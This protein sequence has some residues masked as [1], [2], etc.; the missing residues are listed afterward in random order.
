MSA[1]YLHYWSLRHRPFLEQPFFYG[2]PQR[3]AIAGLAYLVAG[4][5]RFARLVADTG[6]GTTCLLQHLAAMRGL[7]DCAVDI[8]FSDA[9][10]WND[11][12]LAPRLANALHLPRTT[13]LAE[14]RRLLKTNLRRG[15]RN[16]WFVDR[17]STATDELLSS[18][19]DVC[20]EMLIVVAHA[21]RDSSGLPGPEHHDIELNP[22]DLE[23]TL[24]YVERGLEHAAGDP[25]I[26][27]DAASVR[28]HELSEGRIGV[29]TLLAEHAMHQAAVDN[30]RRVSAGTI[31]VV[32]ARMRTDAR[33]TQ[34]A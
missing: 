17:A 33:N 28:L 3:E 10:N 22:L 29:M 25:A 12:R 11:D 21:P 26:F 24:R 8:L 13:S 18:W 4:D 9:S 30:D 19:C 34:A 7:G 23:D 1:D 2:T 14:S 32:A 5:R 6:C 20:D 31:D 16:V 15:V 27:S